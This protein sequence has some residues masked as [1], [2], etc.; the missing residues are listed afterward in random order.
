M[1]WQLLCCWTWLT[2]LCEKT[3]TKKTGFLNISKIK[4]FFLF[5]FFKCPLLLA[6]RK[7]RFQIV[8]QLWPPAPLPDLHATFFSWAAAENRSIGTKISPILKVLPFKYSHHVWIRRVTSCH[9]QLF[10]HLNLQNCY[11]KKHSQRDSFAFGAIYCFYW[12]FFVFLFLLTSERP[13]RPCSPLTE[14]I[15]FDVQLTSFD[16][17]RCQPKKHFFFLFEVFFLFKF[18]H[19]GE[20]ALKVAGILTTP[21]L[22]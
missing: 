14:G 1:T 5:F 16:I 18:L 15:W 20:W 21:P 4:F 6:S 10:F 22:H 9:H 2:G 13:T 11:M 12:H 3:T 7:H 17:R 8:S 19:T